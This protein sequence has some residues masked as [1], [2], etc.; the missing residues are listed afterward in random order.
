MV[1]REAREV[2]QQRRSRSPTRPEDRVRELV[3]AELPEGHCGR[4]RGVGVCWLMRLRRMMSTCHETDTKYR[5]SCFPYFF[6]SARIV[7]LS[8]SVS[9]IG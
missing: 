2:S 8:R 1:Q 3:D 9:P 6:G 4:P 7:F 5:E